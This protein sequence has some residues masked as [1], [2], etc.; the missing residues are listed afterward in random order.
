MTF[1]SPLVSLFWW[2]SGRLNRL[3]GYFTLSPQPL[4]QVHLWNMTPCYLLCL[5][6]QKC[7]LWHFHLTLPLHKLQSRLPVHLNL[8]HKSHPTHLSITVALLQSL[9]PPFWSRDECIFTCI[10]YY[11]RVSVSWQ[12]GNTDDSAFHGAL[13]DVCICSHA[14]EG[15]CALQVHS[16]LMYRFSAAGLCSSTL[17]QI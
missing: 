11:F 12:Y 17:C 2:P 3:P 13:T 7:H 6:L 16:Q 15:E 5:P 1:C 9:L 10:S 14:T 8:L 4:Y